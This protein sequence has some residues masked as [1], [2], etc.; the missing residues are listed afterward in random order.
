MLFYFT[1]TGNCLYV[2]KKI[3]SKIYSIPQEL[4]KDNLNYQ[5]NQIGIVSPIYAGELPKTVRRFIEKANFETDYFYLLLTYGSNDSVATSWSK[6]FC[7]T[8]NLKVDYIQT[9]KMVDNY[10]PAF[11]MEKEIALDK[12][13]D[14]QLKKAKTNLS[15]QVHFIPKPDDEAKKLYEQVQQK[16]K[17]QPYLNNGETIIMSNRC[18]GCNICK[19]VC[20][21]GNI[22]IVDGKAKR[23]NS[24]C[25]FCLACVH[26]C[27][28]KAIDLKEDRNNQARY[29]HPFV[30][31][32]EIVKANHQ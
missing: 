6:N 9:I 30:S 12:K 29:R 2:A 8:N 25:D 13:V 14:E 4:K 24:K 7:Q 19:Q 16:F 22:E 32:K 21:I 23:L 3:E 5:A 1:A 10:L 15:N 11:D 27:P 17:E 26:N 28:F 31:L 18:V 20:P